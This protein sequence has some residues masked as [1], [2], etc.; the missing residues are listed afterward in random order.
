MASRWWSGVDSHLGGMWLLQAPEASSPGAPT[1]QG[2]F[3]K[4][5]SLAGVVTLRRAPCPEVLQARCVGLAGLASA[6]TTI[7]CN[8]QLGWSV[9]R[10]HQHAGQCPTGNYRACQQACLAPVAGIVARVLVYGTQVQVG[11]VLVPGL[12]WVGRVNLASHQLLQ[13]HNS[14][15]EGFRL[16]ACTPDAAELEG[17][18]TYPKARALCPGW[19]VQALEEC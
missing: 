16:D 9:P 4:T 3:T 7:G 17:A 13:P 11:H 14:L 6:C 8:R 18:A 15:I 19:P 2:N 5:V 1:M 12:C 10:C